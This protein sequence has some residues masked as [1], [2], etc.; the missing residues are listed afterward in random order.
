LS[1]P[2]GIVGSGAMAEYHAKRLSGIAGVSIAAVCDHI[3]G[4]AREFALS[5]GIPASFSDPVDMCASGEVD[6]AS[7]ASYDGAHAASAIAA[8]ERGL[9]VFCEKPMA[10][11]LDEAESM[12]VAVRRAASRGAA[13]GAAAP[14]TAVPA[15]VNFSKRNGGLLDLASS[16][17]AGGRIGGLRRI[18]LGYLQ[19]WLLQDSWGDW[20]TTPRWRWRLLESQSTYGALGDLGSHLFDAALV[21]ASPSLVGEGGGKGARLEARSC[22]AVRFVP[23][24]EGAPEGRGSF[25]SFEA[26]LA[27]GPVEVAVKAGWRFPGNLDEFKAVLHCEGGRIEVE[28]G[29]SR[30]SLRVVEDGGRSSEV[31]ASPFASTYERFV[32]LAEGRSSP[33]QGLDPDFERGLAVQRAIVDCALLAGS[34]PE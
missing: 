14:G 27:L 31:E 6:A 24:G 28:P 4:K 11:R 1:L 20:R 8:L 17:A 30:S 19:S 10:R 22:S 15:I 13:D 32:L 21:L 25:E 33:R 3:P 16:L 34:D 9:P 5:R 23:S 2:I 7:I 29:R 18:E 26:E 12:A